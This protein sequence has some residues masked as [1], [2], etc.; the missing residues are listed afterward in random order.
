RGRQ[1]RV[2]AQRGGNQTTVDENGISTDAYVHA[3]YGLAVQRKPRSVLMIGCGGGTL[4]T[5]LHGS[6]V[7]V[8]TVDI[9]PAAIELAYTVFGMPR[10]V[11]SHAGDGLAFM[12]ATRRKFDVVVIDAFVGEK[13]PRQFKGPNLAE[14]AGRCLARDG[15]VLFNVCLAGRRDRTADAIGE[16]FVQCGWPAKLLDEPGTDR[17][18]IVIAGRVRGLRKPRLHLVPQTGVA[19]LRRRLNAAGFREVRK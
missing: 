1:A 3:L 6:G 14:A 5:M 16:M 11:R 19:A 18:A 4:A 7:K 17:N 9:D 2:F 12:Q 10:G 8:T 15:L 13:I